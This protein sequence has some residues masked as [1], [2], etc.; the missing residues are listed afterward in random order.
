M[1][2]FYLTCNNLNTTLGFQC[3]APARQKFDVLAGCYQSKAEG[4]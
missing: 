3:D 2:A 1:E 4:I